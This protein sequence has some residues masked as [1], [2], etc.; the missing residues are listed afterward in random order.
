M[1]D[2]RDKFPAGYENGFFI[3][4]CLFD[5]VTPDMTIYKEEILVRIRH[6]PCEK[7]PRGYE[8]N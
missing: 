4:G 1:V 3:G 5:H 6:C 2:G 7:F 8:T